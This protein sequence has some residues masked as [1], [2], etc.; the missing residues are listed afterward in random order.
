MADHG[1]TWESFQPCRGEQSFSHAWSAHPLYHLMQTVGGV[2]QSTPAW[3]EVVFRPLFHDTSC[4]TTIPTPHGNIHSRWRKC[5]DLID[6]ELALPEGIC[7]RVLLPGVKRHISKGTSR[8]QIS[9]REPVGGSGQ[10]EFLR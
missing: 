6:V 5:G 10:I 8:W 1:T 2:V 9:C 7:A 4:D 3:R